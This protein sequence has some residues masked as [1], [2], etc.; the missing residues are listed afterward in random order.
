MN[1]NPSDLMASVYFK[2][3]RT[4]HLWQLYCYFHLWKYNVEIR[5]RDVPESWF[6]NNPSAAWT[7]SRVL[8]TLSGGPLVFKQESLLHGTQSRKLPVQKS[9]S[10]ISYLSITVL[11]NHWLI[12]SVR[13]ESSNAILLAFQCWWNN[14]GLE[15]AWLGCT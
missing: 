13:D 7:L 14:S 15:V 11:K 4:G 5:K 1:A 9:G 10:G 8:P 3:P 12:V 6:V 2:L